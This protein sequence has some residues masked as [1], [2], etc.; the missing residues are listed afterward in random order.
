MR[1]MPDGNWVVSLWPRR[2]STY[3]RASPAGSCC[4][5][6]SVREFSTDMMRLFLDIH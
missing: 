4:T 3:E 6:K 2:N 1:R 5:A